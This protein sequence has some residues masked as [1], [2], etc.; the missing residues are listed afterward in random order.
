MECTHYRPVQSPC[1]AESCG[2]SSDLSFP[3]PPTPLRTN[4]V[5]DTCARITRY[6]EVEEA[7]SALPTNHELA[8]HSKNVTFTLCAAFLDGL[9]LRQDPDLQLRFY[10]QHRREQHLGRPVIYRHD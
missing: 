1:F 10:E 9:R 7:T 6:S 5:E 2:S 3:I 8:G 4:T